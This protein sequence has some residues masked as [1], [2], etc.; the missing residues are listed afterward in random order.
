MIQEPASVGQ[1][2]QVLSAE[3]SRDLVLN[4]QASHAENGN[5]FRGFH[6]ECWERG[7]IGSWCRRKLLGT[8]VERSK[9]L[10]PESKKQF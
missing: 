1:K 2:L 9:D 5:L 4:M 6:L 10:E 7:T 8:V 3:K